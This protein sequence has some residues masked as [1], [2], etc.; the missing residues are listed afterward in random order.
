MEGREGRGVKGMRRGVGGGEY[1]E[2]WGRGKESSLRN[3]GGG[4]GG[5]GSERYEEGCGRWGV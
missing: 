5:K 3:E 1:K 2:R 4:E